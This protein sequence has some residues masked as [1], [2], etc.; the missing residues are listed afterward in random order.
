MGYERSVCAFSGQHILLPLPPMGASALLRGMH[1]IIPWVSLESVKNQSRKELHVVVQT[2]HPAVRRVRHEGRPDVQGHPQLCS[3][4]KA[5][6]GYMRSK[7][8]QHY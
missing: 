8:P 3:V 2:C 6:L 1:C 4:F 5:T 7:R